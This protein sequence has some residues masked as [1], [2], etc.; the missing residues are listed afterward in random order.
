MRSALELKTTLLCLFIFSKWMFWRRKPENRIDMIS[1][2]HNT[3][4][5][6]YL[7][8]TELVYIYINL[9]QCLCLNKRAN[10]LQVSV[11]GAHQHRSQLFSLSGLPLFFQR[12]FSI[13][14][15]SLCLHTD[16]GCFSHMHCIPERIKPFTSM[17]S[18]WERKC[19]NELDRTL[20]R[21]L[22][23]FP[24]PSY[25]AVVMMMK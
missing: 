19:L 4:N 18:T 15:S 3:Y 1:T 23:S 12:L 8:I 2:M 6:S 17:S 10:A 7:F 5:L 9:L 14:Q 16:F 11:P 24:P 13:L 21:L 25:K 22:P 20:Q